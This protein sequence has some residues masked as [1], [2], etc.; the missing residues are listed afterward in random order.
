MKID[1]S[2]VEGID[3]GPEE[4]AVALAI[5]RLGHTLKLQIIAEGIE[6]DAQLA[7][8]R[9]RGCHLGQGFLLGRPVPPKR[10]APLT[11]VA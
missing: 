7:E 11:A 8:L 1:R 10:S 9:S 6:T 3:Q 5:I 4:A 2:F